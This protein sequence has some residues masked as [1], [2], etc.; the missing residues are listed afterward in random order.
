MIRRLAVATAMTLALAACS[1]NPPA[2]PDAGAL[3][4]D[5][6]MSQR[7]TGA[8]PPA[9]AGNK[10]DAATPTAPDAGGGVGMD[11]TVFWADGSVTGTVLEQVAVEC[12]KPLEL[13]NHWQEGAPVA[14]ELAHHVRVVL[15]QLARQG[16]QPW[17]MA[18]ASVDGVLV[19][20]SHLE[21]ERWRPAPGTIG[22]TLRKYELLEAGRL[23]PAPG[24]G[25]P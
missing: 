21:A 1:E 9:D 18:N 20:K 4:S 25:R 3:P 11:A 17:Q 19:E 6:G 10:P 14:D 13:C 7:D 23:H 15:P 24:G 16:L 12:P 5:T 2:S 8:V 22:R